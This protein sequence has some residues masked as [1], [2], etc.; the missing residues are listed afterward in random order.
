MDYAIIDNRGI[1]EDFNNEDDALNSIDR[2]RD[3]NTISGDLKV[4]KILAVDN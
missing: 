4:I 1:I 2:V 3:E